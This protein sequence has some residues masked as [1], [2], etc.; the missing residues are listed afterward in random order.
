MTRGGCEGPLISIFSRGEK[1]QDLPAPPKLPAGGLCNGLPLARR[2]PRF[3]L[4]DRERRASAAEGV[5]RGKHKGAKAYPFSAELGSD[6][7]A[8]A[9]T[10]PAGG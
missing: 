3:R 6:R 10:G 8:V 2:G 1:R 4:S 9:V 7:R 5:G